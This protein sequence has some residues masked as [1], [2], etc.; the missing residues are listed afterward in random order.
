MAEVRRGFPATWRWAAVVLAACAPF[1]PVVHSA[2]L[3]ASPPPAATRS[4]YERNTNWRVL[5]GQGVRAGR[6]GS[7]GLVVLQ[8]GRPADN[9]R[10]PGTMD[11]SGHFVTLASVEAAAESYIA[12]YFATA[13]PATTLDVAIGTNDSCSEGTYCYGVLCGC[14]DEP[15]SYYLWGQALA[16]AVVAV[17]SWTVNERALH[18][19]TDVV[20]VVA[21]DDAEPSFDPEFTHT[22]DVLAGYAAA[23]G[24]PQPAM[25]DDGSAEPQYWTEDQ[26]FEVAYGF[27]P[28]IPMPEVYYRA[29]ADE[30]VRLVE[31]AR[32]HYRREVRIFGVLAQQGAG[33]FAPAMAYAEMR[34]AL[35]GARAS[36]AIAW[37]SVINALPPLRGVRPL[38]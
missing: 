18:R 31:Y 33:A 22:Y 36:S 35:A 8:F 12:G 14:R 5:Y 7:Q 24:G 16:D 1:L 30:W 28:D 2:L 10:G 17:G 15:A 21:A 29:Q 19:Y 20:D 3:P 11:F 37:L 34:A 26:L 13:P 23:V 6:A 9:G 27:R 32:A 4:Y 38:L 25:V